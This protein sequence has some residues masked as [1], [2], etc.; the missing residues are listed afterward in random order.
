MSRSLPIKKLKPEKPKFDPVGHVYGTYGKFRVIG[1]RGGEYVVQA[2]DVA[3]LGGTV[4][5]ARRTV[6]S[7]ARGVARRLD[8]VVRGS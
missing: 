4:D 7:K 5:V 3:V 6:L 2:V 1:A 8:E